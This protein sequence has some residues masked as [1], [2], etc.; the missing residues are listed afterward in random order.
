MTFTPFDFVDEPELD[1]PLL[2]SVRITSSPGWWVELNDKK[3]YRVAEGSFEDESVTHRRAE[4]SSPFLEGTYVTNALRE[5]VQ[6]P[7]NVYVMGQTAY[8]MRSRLA[9]L[10]ELLEQPQFQVEYTVD[11]ARTIWNC[12]ASDYST[13]TPR[14]FLHSKMALL[15]ANLL[16]DP[17]E[18]LAEEVS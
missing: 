4:A 12:Y 11:D 17:T 1:R 5:N 15:K 14:A 7:L 9:R 16:R 13:S 2:L 3:A 18:Y 10:K 6:V 8:E